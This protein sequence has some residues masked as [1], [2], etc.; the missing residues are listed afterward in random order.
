MTLHVLVHAVVFL[1][2]VIIEL[3]GAELFDVPVVMPQ[4]PIHSGRI[5]GMGGLD[6]RK[7]KQLIITRTVE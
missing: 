3:A 2:A 1:S 5:T 7:R 4:H 6:H